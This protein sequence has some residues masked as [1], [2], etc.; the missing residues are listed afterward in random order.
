MSPQ[1]QNEI[2]E[3]SGAVIRD[4]IIA[5]VK[6][7]YAYSVLADES[8]DISGKEQLSIGVRFVDEEQMIVR[9]ELLGFVELVAMDAKTIATAIDNFIENAGLDPEK[10]VGQ[11]YDGCSTMAG[12][13]GGVQ[14]IMREKYKKAL[15]FHCASH[16]LNLVMN[17][18][19]QILVIR[20]AISTVK[21]IIKFFRESV[22]RRK[23]APN[24]PL[25]CE[26][27]WSQKYKSIAIF[28][29]HYVSIVKALEI[30]SRDGNTATRKVAFQL[31]CTATKSEFIVSVRLIAK[32][33][34][35]LQPV[36][37][38]VQSKSIDMLQCA[39]HI[40]KILVLVK[41]HRETADI[42]SES[43]IAEAK[44]ITDN[45]EI[46]FQGS[47][48]AERQVHR[49]N[50][51]AQNLCEFWKRIINSL[52]PQPYSK[53]LLDQIESMINSNVDFEFLTCNKEE[54]KVTII[55][56]SLAAMWITDQELQE[57]LNNSL[58]EW[59]DFEESPS[60]YSLSEMEESGDDSDTSQGS[61]VDLLINDVNVDS[62][63]IPTGAGELVL[64]ED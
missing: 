36:V 37:N 54:H 6:K 34:A 31:H 49:S 51:P 64:K 7:A 5:Q 17:D 32:Y 14:K 2:I 55:N 48:I 19:N 20:N 3:L 52:D 61:D 1:I 60:E 43:I 25:F 39:N 38:V 26:I 21:E 46:D 40:N 57:E 27:R 13:D 63:G 11:G 59:G 50:P 47:R 35:I 41:N 23:Y 29:E 62:D 42:T 8:S 16:K 33:S 10:C 15:Y 22:L 12:N 44:K 4:Y 18:L 53:Y 9:E 58:D 56:Y 30:L 24:I 28:R 45:L